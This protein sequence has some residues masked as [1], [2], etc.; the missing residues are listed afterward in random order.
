VMPGTSVLM[1][2]TAVAILPFLSFFCDE[3]LAS[4]LSFSS[5]FSLVLPRPLLLRLEAEDGTGTGSASARRMDRRQD[6]FLVNGI[7]GEAV[8]WRRT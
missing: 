7:G 5:P 8:D 3:T 2:S 4:F 1:A 6:F